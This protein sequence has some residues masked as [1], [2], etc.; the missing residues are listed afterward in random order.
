MGKKIAWREFLAFEQCGAQ[1]LFLFWQWCVWVSVA[2]TIDRVRELCDWTR[3]GVAF[4]PVRGRAGTG[5]PEAISIGHRWMFLYHPVILRVLPEGTFATGG[6]ILPPPN[7]FS[8]EGFTL[9]LHPGC[10]EHHLQTFLRSMLRILLR[11][12]E[13]EPALTGLVKLLRVSPWITWKCASC[14]EAVRFVRQTVDAFAEIDPYGTDLGWLTIP[15]WIRLA[16]AGGETAS[17]GWPPHPLLVDHNDDCGRQ[18]LRHACSAFQE[19]FGKLCQYTKLVS[20]R[21][22]LLGACE[23]LLVE[24][25]GPLRPE[26]SVEERARVMAVSLKDWLIKNMKFIPFSTI[27]FDRLCRGLFLYRFGKN[28]V[29]GRDRPEPPPPRLWSFVERQPFMDIRFF[30]DVLAVVFEPYDREI[31]QGIKI[32]QGVGGASWRVFDASTGSPVS[33][34][35]SWFL[36]CRRHHP[37]YRTIGGADTPP[38][39]R[40]CIRVPAAEHP[41]KTAAFPFVNETNVFVTK[42]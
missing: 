16:I 41:S 23:R 37:M 31:L 39:L 29:M 8:L 40:R 17:E 11:Q 35:A 42:S 7:A 5:Y 10:V 12:C 6:E 34:P 22:H 32:P 21:Q 19:E 13:K 3:L 14:E 36:A 1:N 28:V 26:E 27:D 15:E 9:S 24:T 4:L 25:G 30:A 18:D 2:T 38:P 33:V 20:V